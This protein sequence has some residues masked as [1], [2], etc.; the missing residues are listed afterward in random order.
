MTVLYWASLPPHPHELGIT[1]DS[2]RASRTDVL[3]DRLRR[4]HRDT[5]PDD[6]FVAVLT[7]GEQ[8]RAP[9]GLVVFRMSACDHYWI[10]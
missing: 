10:D 6:E 7:G 4:L 3:Q 5:H 9:T 2:A 1:L 8:L